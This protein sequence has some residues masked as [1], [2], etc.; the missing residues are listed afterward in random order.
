[1]KRCLTNYSTR[2]NTPY[3]FGH[4]KL[5]HHKDVWDTIVLDTFDIDPFLSFYKKHFDVGE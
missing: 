5:P 1:M 3:K 2:L 4:F